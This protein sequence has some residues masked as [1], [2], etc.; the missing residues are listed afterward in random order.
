MNPSG[1]VLM[2]FGVWALCQVFGGDALQR[3][4]IVT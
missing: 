4:K 2:I 3:L 1:A